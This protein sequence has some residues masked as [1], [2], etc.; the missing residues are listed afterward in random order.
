MVTPLKWGILGPGNIANK[1]A[2]GLQ[3][4]PDAAITAVGSRTPEKLQAFGD[5]FNIPN[6]HTSYEALVSDPEV[7]I[8]YIAMPHVFH[9][10]MIVLALEHGKHVVCE[11]PICINAQQTRHAVEMARKHKRFLMEAMWTRF[12][13]LMADVRRRIAAGEIGEVR[14]LQVDFGFRAGVDPKGR[15]FDPKLAGGSLLDVGVYCMAMSHMLFGA[16]QTITGVATMGETHV[17]EQAAWVSQH[18]NGTIAVCSSAVRTSTPHEA[19]IA[20]TDGQIRIASPWWIPEKM[21]VRVNGKEPEDCHFPMEGTGMNYEAAAAMACI[22]DGKIESDIIP[23]DESIAIAE[24]MDA[25]R[26]Q[27]G[28]VYPMEG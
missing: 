6:R 2:K 1:F 11:K 13:P 8:I 20:G 28:F 9:H 24:S 16:P 14:M 5:A 25:L 17:D 12:F 10:D 15:L 23:H 4:L 26:K 21:T 27:W 7:D 22:R 18:K 3:V 19:L